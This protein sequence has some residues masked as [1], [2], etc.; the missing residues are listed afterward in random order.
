LALID[1]EYP[2]YGLIAFS[3][4]KRIGRPSGVLS[5]AMVSGEPSAFAIAAHSVGRCHILSVAFGAQFVST[6]VEIGA[7][8]RIRNLLPPDTHRLI[9][10]SCGY[11]SGLRKATEY[12]PDMHTFS[13]HKHLTCIGFLTTTLV[14]D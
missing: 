10:R 9:H 4:F 8:S 11:L 2:I 13:A 6:P 12:A 7:V 14:T 3:M 1:T 5:G